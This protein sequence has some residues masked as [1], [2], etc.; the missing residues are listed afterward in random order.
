[1]RHVALVA[2]VFLCLRPV[3]AAPPP[4]ADPTLEPWFRSLHIPGS[5]VLCCS[6]SDCRQV[7]SRVVGGHY[8]AFIAEKWRDVPD[9]RVLTRPD[10]PTGHAV[11]CWTPFA[12]VLCFVK[13]PES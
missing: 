6:M 12:G 1:M 8:Q 10:N 5:M 13:A 9:D 3:L 11:A 4:D 2:M 7:M